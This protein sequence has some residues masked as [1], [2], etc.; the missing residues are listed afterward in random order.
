MTFDFEKKGEVKITGDR[1]I[2][3]L[4]QQ[5]PV[6]TSVKTPAY[7][8]LF[9]I[10]EKSRLLNKKDNKLFHSIVAKLLYI[11]KRFRPDILTAISFLTT[12][13]NSSTEQDMKKLTTVLKI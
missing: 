6:T 5:F 12:R 8:D 3:E 4:L 2:K 13:V 1:Y 10:S 9:E 11:A 7:T